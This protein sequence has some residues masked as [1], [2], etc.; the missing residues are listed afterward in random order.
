[1]AERA[2]LRHVICHNPAR[3]ACLTSCSEQDIQIAGLQANASIG[4]RTKT[5][6]VVQDHNA[7]VAVKESATAGLLV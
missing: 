1:M 7:R 4:A 2:Y 5:H 3:Q 6:E